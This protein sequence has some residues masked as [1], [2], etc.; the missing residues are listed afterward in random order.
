MT[1]EPSTLC[2]CSSCEAHRKTLR[3]DLMDLP[4]ET[5]ETTVELLINFRYSLMRKECKNVRED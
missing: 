1:D 5:S 2:H 4:P 3:K